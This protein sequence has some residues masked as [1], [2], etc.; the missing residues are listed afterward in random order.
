MTEITR[1]FAYTQDGRRIHYRR[2]GSGPPLVLLH[3]SPSSSRVQIPLLRAWAGDFTVIALDTP[4]FGLSDPLPGGRVE[5]ADLAEALAETLDALAL[6]R[7]LL[8]GRHTG[9][10]IAVEFARR[11]PRRAAFVLT[12]GYTITPNLPSDAYLSAYLPPIEPR[13][14][15][16]H[17]L[18][19]WH[20]YRQ[21]FVFWPWNNPAGQ[22]AD[23]DLPALADLQRGVIELLEAGS[24][25]AGVYA[26]A[27]RYRWDE[28]L[29]HLTTPV[30]FGVR[31]GDSQFAK[32]DY[33][34]TAGITVETVPR[35]HAEAARHEL[36]ILRRHA[37]GLGSA[38]P[39]RE[40]SGAGFGYVD[41]GDGRQMF[42]RQ[43]GDGNGMPLVMLPP[44]PGAS[45]QVESLMLAL[46]GDRRVLAIDPPGNGYSDALAGELSV[47]AWAAA[48]VRAL[49]VLGIG[50]AALYGRHGGAALA[51]ELATAFPERFAA[52]VLDAPAAVLAKEREAIAAQYCPPLELR[53]DGS[54]LTTL[55][56]FVRDQRLWWPWFAHSR[57]AMHPGRPSIDPQEL[58]A[59]VGTLALNM[60]AI[61]PSWRAVLGY[62]LLERLKTLSQPLMIGAD[63]DDV[64][65][66]CLGAAQ[67]CRPDAVHG[68]F[69]A[70]R[71]ATI[72]AFLRGL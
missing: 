41:I 51:V 66:A 21:Q 23:I 63:V 61:A 10:S 65:I 42:V 9:G 67:A 43:Y 14:D 37:G 5:I 49:D 60:E 45:S 20:R 44:T 19:L 34:R 54:H 27:L 15:G 8:Y 1:H 47:P 22:R 38:A 28:P 55:W 68:D 13:W 2:A 31:P 48:T 33:L 56:H 72:N 32:A 46:Q 16:G 50:K 4:G 71:H 52:V 36:E 6:D 40:T 24:G 18:W 30:C 17:M 7:V 39:A 53:W 70:G 3:A 26:A 35:D 12:D 62:P 58:H 25:Y 11:H 29:P 64:L 69:G 59:E 57:A